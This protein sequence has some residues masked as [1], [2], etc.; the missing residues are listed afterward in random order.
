M[1]AD[2]EADVAAMQGRPAPLAPDCGRY[3]GTMYGGAFASVVLLGGGLAMLLVGV[4]KV[5]VERPSSAIKVRPW[6][7]PT[8]AGL[9]LHTTF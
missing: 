4:Q 6:L 1:D 2:Y 8:T 9:G 7:S 5:P 3:D